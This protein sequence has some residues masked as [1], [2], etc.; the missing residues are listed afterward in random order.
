MKKTTLI[1]L[2]A[3]AG[4]LAAAGAFAAQPFSWNSKPYTRY[5]SAGTV[6][7]AGA[8]GRRGTVRAAYVLPSKWRRMT[9][10]TSRTARFAVR[11]SCRHVVTITPRVVLA[12]DIPA[13]ERAA[14]EVPGTGRHVLAEGTREAAA[15]R[16]VRPRGSADVVGVLVQPLPRLLGVHDPGPGRRYYAELRARTRHGVQECHSGG[17]RTVGTGIGDAFAAGS[18]GGFVP[19]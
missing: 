13:G 1:L 5:S 10:R 11:N 9:S 17:P 15:F 19:R 14:S 4:L 16:V 18:A 6:T 2:C 12:D 8:D 7:V 3:T